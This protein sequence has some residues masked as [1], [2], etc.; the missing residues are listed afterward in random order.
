MNCDSRTA[1][2]TFLFTDIEGSTRLWEESPD[3]MR[4]AL[5]RHDALTRSAVEDHAGTVVKMTGDGVCAAFADALDAVVAVLQLQR[6]LADPEATNGVALSLRSGLH[7][8]VVER[9][10]DDYF[11][12]AV[13]RAARI[14]GAAHGGQIILSQAVFDRVANRLP[15]PVSLRDLGSVRLKDLARPERLYQ[16]L[17]PQLRRDF[18]ALRSLEAIPNNLPRQLSSFIGREHVLAE[19][20]KLLGN[21]RLLTLVGVGGLGKTRLT[22]QVGADM[23]DDFP[24]GAWF[25]ELAPLSD[26]RLVPQ[27]VA[28]VLG[29]KEEAGRPVQEALVKFVK[30]RQLL[31]ILDNCEHL[32]HACADLAKAMLQAGPQ[33]K[34]LASSREALHVVG[35]M[36]YP[37]ST[38][39]V[40][41]LRKNLPVA[42]LTQYDAVRLFCDR[43]LAAQP[44]FRFSDTNAATVAEICR[45]LDGI[46]LA[47]ELAAARVRALSMEAIAE[48]LSDRFRLLTG[49]DQ[50]A[51]P[52]QQ[53]LRACIDWS[54]DLLTEPERALLRRLAVFAVGFTLQA[55]EAVGT[56]GET[57]AS[58]VLDL[59]TR[60][61]DKSLV[62]LEVDGTRYRL[63]E[64]IRQYAQE[65]LDESGDGDLAR[66]QHLGFFVVLA[67]EARSNLRGTTQGVWLSR[68]DF[69]RENLLSACAWCDVADGG[70]ELGLRLVSATH[71]YWFNRGLWELGLQVTM[72]ALG[73]DG[74]DARGLPRRQALYCAGNFA[75]FMGRDVQA[76]TCAREL[77]AIARGLGDLD[78]VA[79]A[80]TLLGRVSAS[81][82]DPT[83][84]RRQFEESLVVARQFGDKV[85]IINALGSLADLHYDT[86]N[87]DLAQSHYEEV[88]TLARESGNRSNLASSLARLAKVSIDRGAG[89]RAREILL[90]AL[91]II[92]EIGSKPQGQN[93]LEV[94]AALAAI[95]GEPARAAR[96]S[97]AA[98]TLGDAMGYPR[99]PASNAFLAPRI[100][101]ARTALGDAFVAAESG[102]RALRYEEALAE[103]RTWLQNPG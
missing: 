83:T 62:E 73:R 70:A 91:S 23:L 18:P 54:H 49:G 85:R 16:V 55:A 34:M 47:L 5:A 100:A 72:A 98:Q 69:D 76:Q 92:D 10:D 6:G 68:L 82:G 89:D 87:L 20:S 24:D 67:E 101:G 31:L 14:M 33:V 46:P 65:H 52:R 30:D 77:L 99:D 102:G 36:I 61:V 12:G 74:A 103:V 48:R 93:V 28:S 79:G 95:V 43:A 9:R 90:D 7:V 71:L 44:G 19:V 42:A 81:Q 37:L 75:H 60:L 26:A 21:T 2:V 50:T 39:A 63:L 13:N 3:K 64:T 57:G 58:D 35:E 32:A 78:R 29:V 59:L 41:D 4:L 88:A 80:L 17:D 25:V 96:F 97:G 38:L 40:P 86:G 45:R 22:L 1:A 51:L 15:L 94:A 11:G 53:T 56:G 27:A 84:A 66:T 8:G